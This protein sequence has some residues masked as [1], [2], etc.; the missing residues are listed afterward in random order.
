MWND[1]KFLGIEI[2]TVTG[3][4][5][6]LCKY[7]YFMPSKKLFFI[8]HLYIKYFSSMAALKKTNILNDRYRYIQYIDKIILKNILDCLS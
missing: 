1:E 8:F 7:E 2:G 5:F 6:D 4:Q 3:Q